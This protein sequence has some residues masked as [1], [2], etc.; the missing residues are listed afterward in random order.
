MLRESGAHQLLSDG[1]VVG[2][3]KARVCGFRGSLVS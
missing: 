3:N 2:G 1:A